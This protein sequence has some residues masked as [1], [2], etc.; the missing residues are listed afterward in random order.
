MIDCYDDKKCA[1]CGWNPDS[2]VR[3]KRVEK[4]LS[5][6]RERAKNSSKALN[7]GGDNLWTRN[8]GVV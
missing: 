7:Q 8:Y 6:R 3:K 4:M 1:S 5:E 2:G